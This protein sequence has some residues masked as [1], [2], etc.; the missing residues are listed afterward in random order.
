[1]NLPLGDERFDHVSNLCVFVFRRIVILVNGRGVRM[2]SRRIDGLVLTR[3][4]A[5]YISQLLGLI[6]MGCVTPPAAIHKAMSVCPDLTAGKGLPR[7]HLMS[8]DLKS[9]WDRDLRVI[10]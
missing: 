8:C 10:G 5:L 4:I 7:L 6:T 9:R 3:E 1:M 2:N